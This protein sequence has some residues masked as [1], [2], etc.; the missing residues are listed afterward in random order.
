MS[1]DVS[2]ET[3]RLHCSSA[4]SAL[5]VICA[6]LVTG[7]SG[8]R[9]YAV[10][11]QLDQDPDAPDGFPY[12]NRGQSQTSGTESNGC[13]RTSIGKK[14]ICLL[15]SAMSIPS[16]ILPKTRIPLASMQRGHRTEDH[17]VSSRCLPLSRR[18]RAESNRMRTR[19]SLGGAAWSKMAW[20]R[21]CCRADVL[22]SRHGARQASAH[23]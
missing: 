9:R 2:R 1:D 20:S 13:S 21:S 6:F 10:T 22:V 14:P 18:R 5:R 19:S 4:M 11:S 16:R 12:D 17:L 8:I 3:R 15:G 23:L 7:N